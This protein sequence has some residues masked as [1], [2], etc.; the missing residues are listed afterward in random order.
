MFLPSLQDH[1]DDLP[2]VPAPH[3]L[4]DELPYLYKEIVLPKETWVS[5]G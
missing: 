3:G 4:T 2:V 5:Y 1:Q